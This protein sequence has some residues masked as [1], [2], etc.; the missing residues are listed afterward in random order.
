MVQNNDVQGNAV[1][2]RKRAEELAD[3]NARRV[4]HDSETMLPETTRRTLRELR[5]HQIELEMQI[6]ELLRTQAEVDRERRRVEEAMQNKERYQRALLDN[7]PFAVWLKDTESR[8]LAVNQMFAETFGYPSSDELVG[9]TDFDITARDFAEAYRA[10]DRA[11]LESRQNK[12]VEEQVVGRGAQ[13][14]FETYKAPVIDKTDKLLGTVGFMRDITERKQSAEALKESQSLYLSFL[15]Q[16]PNAVFRKNREGRFVIVNPQFCRLKGLKKEEIIGRMPME[17]AAREL[18]KEGDGGFSVKYANI[19]ETVHEQ[20]LRNG[21]TYE[22][23]EEYCDAEGRMQYMHVVRMPV[24]D[25]YGTVIGTQGIMFDITAR[26]QA[27]KSLS[28]SEYRLREAQRIGKMGSLDWNLETKEISLSEESK[29]ILGFAKEK[30]IISSDEM[31]NL[32]HPDDMER[33]SQALNAAIANHSTYDLEHRVV[34]PDGTAIHVRATAELIQNSEGKLV[35]L[36]GTLLDITERK[37]TEQL[38]RDMQRRESIGILAGGIAHDFNNLLGAMMGNVSLAASQ[39]PENHPAAVNIEKALSAMERAAN[40]TRQMLAY[41]G[42]GKFHTHAIDLTA[43]V[44]EHVSLFTVSLAKNVKLETHLPSSSVFINGDSAQIEQIIMN[45]IINGGESIG[46][47][48]GVVSISLTESEMNEAE[49]SSYRRLTNIQLS[50]GRYACLEVRD[51]GIGMSRET[52]AKMFDPFFTTKFTGRGLGLSAVLGII[53][54][55]KGG[56][57][58]ESTEGSGTTLRVILPALAASVTAEAPPSDRPPLQKVS[59][60]ILVIDDEEDLASIAQEMLEAGKFKALIELNPLHGIEFYK[61]HQSEIGVV[62][63]DLTMPEMPGKDV[64]DALMTINPQVKIIISSGYSEQ[65]MAKKIGNVKV[66]GFIQK[67]YRME[68]LLALMRKLLA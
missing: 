28:E 24:R 54:G 61:Q 15:D 51:T 48:Q 26:K 29:K 64:A 58:V 30:N 5:V 22:T 55:H 41:S 1:E 45:L 39:L 23:E 46:D 67:P 66:T 52:L 44:Q 60:T 14:W 18:P 27:E 25:F 63:L 11:V 9:K 53:Q 57:I 2:I 37:T 49:L 4:V 7:F 10:D 21:Q 50:A 19:G 32:I 59:T 68:S 38:L 62:L 56:I 12:N 42:K 33:V 34:R 31:R 40:L 47:R 43:M 13:K 8:F 6:D 20:I 35:R 3:I 65:E 16:L 17:I 36:L